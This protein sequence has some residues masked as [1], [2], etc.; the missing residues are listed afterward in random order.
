MPYVLKNP[1][2]SLPG[3]VIFT[4]AEH[5]DVINLYP[6]L[7][8]KLNIIKD[9]IFGIHVQGDI[10]FLDSFPDQPWIDF[11][12]SPNSSAS[13]FSNVAHKMVNLGA[14]NFQE[15]SQN[16]IKINDIIIVSRA[17]KIKRLFESLLIIKKLF[18]L[19]PDL[20]VIVCVPD[21]RINK[22]KLQYKK[23][24]LDDRFFNETKNVFS[25]NELS[26]ISFIS[27]SRD[28]F[29]NF[30]L[31]DNFL[32]LILSQSRMLMLTSIKEGAPR[33]ITQALVNNTV[34]ALANDMQHDLKSFLNSAN[35]IEI[36]MNDF[37]KSASLINDAL[38][39]LGDFDVTAS[40]KNFLSIN[41]SKLLINSIN[42]ITDLNLIFDNS[43]N[44]DSLDKNLAMHGEKAFFAMSR[45]KDIELF[46]DD[47]E[48]YDQLQFEEKYYEQNPKTKSILEKIYYYLMRFRLKLR[49]SL[50][51]I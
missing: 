14:A 42:S 7:N 30:P 28:S 36:P 33:A 37:H 38:S 16:T 41:S 35:C 20:S 10:S 9:W 13:V 47:L 3:I 6:R 44:L 4:H 15:H 12:L 45:S 8:K 34:V 18:Q 31:S 27:S 46:L 26:K 40:K 11:I 2:K 51:R 5:L 43:W 19:K 23:L 21:E 25:A 24:N 17:S 39:T 50:E 29:G 22:N 1:A 49:K 48:Y 32:N